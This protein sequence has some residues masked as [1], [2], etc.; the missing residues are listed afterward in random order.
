MA[1]WH[2]AQ[3]N[4]A[5]M[6]GANIDDPIMVD[7]VARLNEINALAE[8][9]PGFIWRLK[10]DSNNAT[11]MNPYDDPSILVNLSVWKDLDSLRDYVFQSAHADVM[12][13]RRKWF[14]MM[15]KPHMVL[16]YIPSDH[17]P[18]LAEAKEKL[19]LLHQNGPGPMAFNFK[20]QFLPKEI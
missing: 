15:E 16:W 3:L 18:S 9:H 12:R 10:D 4:I 11:G 20:S 2:L 17:T 6:K 19:E 14:E 7:F 13:Q 5:Q 8:N 1:Q